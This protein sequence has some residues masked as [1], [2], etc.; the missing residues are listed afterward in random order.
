MLPIYLIRVIYIKLY[1]TT[2]DMLACV[3]WQITLCDPIPVWKVMQLF[4]WR[5]VY[6]I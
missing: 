5:A 6:T 1:K 2:W 3:G 4:L